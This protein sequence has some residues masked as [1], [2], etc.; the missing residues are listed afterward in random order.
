MLENYKN[1]RSTLGGFEINLKIE[2][3]EIYK[4]A[5]VD[6]EFVRIIPEVIT[7][8]KTNVGVYYGVI[9]HELETLEV[10]I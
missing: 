1:V 2:A 10:G 9:T 7:N 6:G 3:D 5:A 8:L 4:G